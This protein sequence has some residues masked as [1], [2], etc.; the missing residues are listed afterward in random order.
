MHIPCFGSHLCFFFELD[1]ALQIQSCSRFQIYTQGTWECNRCSLGLTTRDLKR[2]HQAEQQPWFKNKLKKK[3]I[4]FWWFSIQFTLPEVARL[5]VDNVRDEV[6]SYF[7]VQCL[8][9]LTLWVRIP[10]RR[11]VLDTPLCDRVYEWFAPWWWFSP[12]SS[13]IKTDRRD[14]TEI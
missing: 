13:T 10:L 12:V 2:T 8:L 9:P 1:S 6:C 5:C 11:G 3:K 7:I 14:I 4:Y